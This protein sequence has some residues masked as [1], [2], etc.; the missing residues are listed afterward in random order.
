MTN[1]PAKLCRALGIDRT[2]NGHDLHDPPLRLLCGEPIPEEQIVQATRIGIS[3]AQ[4]A[5]W[6]FY[7]QGNPYVSKK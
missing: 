4:D 7:L 3:R 5:R 1:G 2:L 6:R